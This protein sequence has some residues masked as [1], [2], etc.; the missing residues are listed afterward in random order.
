MLALVLPLALTPEQFYIVKGLGALVATILL[1]AHMQIAWG[2]IEKLG[3]RLRYLTLFY[4]AVLMTAAS[5]G[6]TATD[7]PINWW[8]VGGFGG[9]ALLV[10]T[11]VVS[12]KE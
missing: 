8:N 5:V 2:S 3:Q 1:V 4:F 10:V 9:A 12:I 6:Q 7:Q 11:M